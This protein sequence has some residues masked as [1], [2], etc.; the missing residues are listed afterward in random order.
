MRLLPVTPFTLDDILAEPT[1]PNPSSPSAISPSPSAAAAA[2][3]KRRSRST[4]SRSTSPRADAGAGRGIRFRQ[5]G[6]R[7]VDPQAPALSAARR[8]SGEIRFKDRDLLQLSGRDIRKVAATTLPSCFRAD[9]LA[10]SAAHHRSR[11]ARFCCC[12][13]SHRRRARAR[14]LEV[15]T[16]SAFPIRSRGSTAIRISSR[17]PAPAT[18]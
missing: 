15:L 10:Q 7:A 4:M 2:A 13:R 3:G 5:I 14:T 17:R 8:P 1:R 9:D 18:S 6:H 12:T 16:R 11:S